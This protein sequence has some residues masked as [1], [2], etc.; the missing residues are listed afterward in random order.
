MLG[1]NNGTKVPKERKGYRS[2]GIHFNPPT[3]VFIKS[4]YNSLHIGF[5]RFFRSPEVGPVVT[6]RLGQSI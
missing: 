2:E 6:G 4:V 3:N 1:G 5:V